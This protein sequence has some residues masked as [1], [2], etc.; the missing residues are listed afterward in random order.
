MKL[1]PNWQTIKALPMFS[2]I[3]DGMAEAAEDVYQNLLKA[4]SK[5]YI[6][7]DNTISRTIKV[8]SEQLND[9]WLY[10]EQFS[11]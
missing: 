4:K 9:L 11:R 10:E 1:K 6:L 5:P 3:V 7:D 2:D 8:H